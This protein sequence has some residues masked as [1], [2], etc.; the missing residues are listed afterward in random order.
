[1]KE[2]VEMGELPKEHLSNHRLALAERM[3]KDFN[4]F[5]DEEA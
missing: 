3:G 1:M 2:L 5:M 4:E